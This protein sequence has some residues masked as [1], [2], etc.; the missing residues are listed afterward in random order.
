MAFAHRCSVNNLLT[1]QLH[2]VCLLTEE[3][4]GVEEQGTDH[5]GEVGWKF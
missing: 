3:V 4:Q 1:S 5:T 2:S